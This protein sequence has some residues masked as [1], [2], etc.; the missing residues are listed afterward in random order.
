MPPAHQGLGTGEEGGLPADIELRLI[1]DLKLTLFD[2]G[3]EILDQLLVKK[4]FFM[5]PLVIKADGVAEA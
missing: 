2:S 5:Q 4:L 3:V 1:P